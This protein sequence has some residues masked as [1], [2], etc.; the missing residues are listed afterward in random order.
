M[1]PESGQATLEYLLIGLVLISMIVALGALWQA[2]S[3]GTFT[4]LVEAHASH[5][6][7][8][9]GGVVDAVLF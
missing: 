2:V 9:I 8:E 7:T 1:N 4:G 6:L 3:D 5:A